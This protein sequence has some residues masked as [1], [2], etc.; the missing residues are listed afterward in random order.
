LLLIS[1]EGYSATAPPDWLPIREGIGSSQQGS[2]V[3]RIK[4]KKG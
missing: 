3:R 2:S 4:L 1:V